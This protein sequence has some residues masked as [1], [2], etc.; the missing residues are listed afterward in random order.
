[1]TVNRNLKVLLGEIRACQVCDLPLGRRPIVAAAPGARI[2]LAGQAPGARVH[3]SGI[4]WD[5]ASGN[6]L[7]EWLGMNRVTFYDANQIAIVPMGF[8]YPGKG[9]SGDLPPRAECAET[10]HHRL[11]PK[12]TNLE[13]TVVIGAHA[14]AYHLGQRQ[15]ASV[16]ETVRSFRKY[17]PRYCVLPHPS[18]RNRPWLVRNPW[19]ETEL[20]P[21]LR[22]RVRDVLNA[23]E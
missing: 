23:P 17:L 10:W 9:H 8:C 3:V 21:K 7:R 19:F 12:L 22:A 16:T 2:L 6:T 11:L 18:P 15:K 4:P 13:L 20:L 1:M 14:Q 5:D